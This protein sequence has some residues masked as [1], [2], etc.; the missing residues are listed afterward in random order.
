[1]FPKAQVD[2]LKCPQFC[3]QPKDNQFTVTEEETNQKIFSFKK[4]ESYNLDFF[5]LKSTKNDEL[6]IKIVGDR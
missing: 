4:L 3:P 5:S 1:M 2:V 6:I